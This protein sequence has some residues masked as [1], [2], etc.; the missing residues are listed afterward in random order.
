MVGISVSTLR[1]IADEM[2]EI[3]PDYKTVQGERRTFTLADVRAIAA[4]H[5]RLQASGLSR[6]ALLAELSR[7]DSEPLI[8]PETLSVERPP[9]SQESAE[10]SESPKPISTLSADTLTPFLAAQDD[11][12]QQIARLSAQLDKLSAARPADRPDERRHLTVYVVTTLIATLLLLAGVT[13]S[14]I[15]ADSRAALIASAIALVFLLVGIFWPS[16]RR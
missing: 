6:S 10:R 16:L 2:S 3:L 13:A 7:P 12:R 1:R 5:A 14:A 8:I 15:F 9:E 4:L 11:T